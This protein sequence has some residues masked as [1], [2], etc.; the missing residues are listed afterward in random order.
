MTVEY[1][2][3][4]EYSEWELAIAHQVRLEDMNEFQ[5]QAI[6]DATEDCEPVDFAFWVWLE[7]DDDAKLAYYSSGLFLKGHPSETSDFYNW[8]DITNVMPRLEPEPPG[9]V[10]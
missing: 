10:S 4:F 2:Q 8:A 3:D 7:G 9:G 6:I 5:K 1:P